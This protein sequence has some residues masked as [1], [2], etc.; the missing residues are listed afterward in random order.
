MMKTLFA[1][2]L[3]SGYRAWR[4]VYGRGNCRPRDRL[5]SD[6]TLPRP[7]TGKY[8][9]GKSRFQWPAKR[10]PPE[11]NKMAAAQ[12]RGGNKPDKVQNLEIPVGLMTCG[13]GVPLALQVEP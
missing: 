1:G 13:P 10:N 9:S 2:R 5:K 11:K 3:R 8:C 6:G 12:A 7:L 4:W